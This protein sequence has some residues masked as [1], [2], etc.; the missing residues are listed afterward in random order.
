MVRTLHMSPSN[1]SGFH[2]RRLGYTACLLA[3]LWMVSTAAVGQEQIA[4]SEQPAAPARSVVA[5]PADA[6]SPSNSTNGSPAEARSGTSGGSREANGTPTEA[7]PRAT[8]ASPVAPMFTP[9]NGGGASV[10]RPAEGGVKWDAIYLRN[11]RGQLVPVPLDGDLKAFLEWRAAKNAPPRAARPDYAITSVALA[12]TAGDERAELTA[13]IRV[14][15]DRA[16]GWVRVPLRLNEAV[17]RDTSYD[18]PGTAAFDEF[19]RDAGYRWSL[20]GQGLHTLT[21]SVFVPVR[22]QSPTR[23]VQ[24][25]LPAT[26]VSQ[27]RI[28]VP[29]RR[30]SVKTGDPLAERDPRSTIRTRAVSDDATEIEIFGLE[31]R[32]DLT[33]QPLPDPAQVEM[34]LESLAS[35]AVKP[36]IDSVLLEVVQSVQARQ[37]SFD[38]L[39]VRL[40]SGFE[41]I[42][43]E[44]RRYA[45]HE[46]LPDERVAVKLTEPGTGPIELR[47]TLQAPLPES[48]RVL[49]EGFEVE[50]ARRQTGDIAVSHVEGLRIARYEA[51]NVHRI[52]AGD[53]IGQPS[54]ASAYRFLRQPFRLGLAVTRNPPGFTVQPEHKLHFSGQRAELTAEFK[55]RVYRGVVESLD[56]AWPN[57][58]AEGW[59]IEPPDMFAP[60]ADGAA[61]ERFDFD[62]D[63][64]SDV[65]RIQLRDRQAGEFT[66]RVRAGRKMLPEP[67]ATV[68]SLPGIDTTS[69]SPADLF[70][71]TADAVEAQLEPT[72]ETALERIQLAD[73]FPLFGEGSMAG[74]SPPASRNE[75]AHYR[76][77]SPSALLAVRLS[78]HE[79]IVRTSADA[80]VELVDGRLLVRQRI[81]YDVRYERL[82]QARLLVPRGVGE[83]VR[84][85][86]ADGA[87]L[88]PSWTDRGDADHRQATIRFSEPRIGWFEIV[89][90]YFVDP[91]TALP[92]VEPVDSKLPLVL[93]TEAPFG[94]LVLSAPP[95]ET[96]EVSVAESGWT[97]QM[98]M[99]DRRQWRT[100]TPGDAIVVRLERASPDIPQHYVVR[101]SLVRTVFD[102][103]GDASIRAQFR[104]RGDFTRLLLHVPEEQ[105]VQALWW[106]HETIAPERLVP[107]DDDGG[108]HRLEIADGTSGAVSGEHLL[109][110]DF[111]ESAPRG[112]TWA[113]ASRLAVARFPA[114]VRVDQS[115][116]EIV[117]PVDL[118][119][120]VTPRGLTPMYEWRRGTAFWTRNVRPGYADLDAW[121]GAGDGPA[122]E[123]MF[124]AGNSYL[125]ARFGPV[126][127][128]EFR[129]MSQSLIVLLGAGLALA[130]GFVL[131]KIPAT[132]DALT[133]LVIAFAGALVGL[134]HAEPVRV[135]LQPALLGLLLA[136]AAAAIEHTI[137]RRRAPSI[138]TLS[139]ASDFYAPSAGGSGNHR[140]LPAGADDPTAVRPAPSPFE[141]VST[142]TAGR[143]R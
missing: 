74:A 71:T 130:A 39:T 80:A 3:A 108:L 59:T 94:A 99:D 10:S 127:A 23:R 57:R 17:L 43:V 133:L 48:G 90:E 35:I 87:V 5:A 100:S 49:L 77:P 95:T 119:L 20:K 24:L 30:V 111:R 109:T 139:A 52:N 105:T 55:V 4:Q 29:M 123:P 114:N 33:W 120:F 126:D 89:A 91:G 31:Q 134:W 70:V 8:G 64:T 19:D 121:I 76:V 131:L 112:F 84:F 113:D 124:E 102:H 37:G 2:V 137:Q 36:T 15:V 41:L 128:L 135:L 38:S 85:L 125:F 13:T 115:L 92:P 82:P 78:L 9:S 88:T 83:Q 143:E 98:A 53:V 25:A 34:V 51:A 141:P 101:R 47:W 27:A 60:A 122:P 28:A 73:A 6:S 116:T 118:H 75:V 66:V 40:P 81:A 22:K 72:A 65:V 44:G 138:I 26:A 11:E 68:L 132:R 58:R 45:S 136:V 32:L 67:E 107:V 97:R 42:A 86:A 63:E 50:H 1:R 61:I 142:T 79:R 140:A 96:V 16:D 21:L 54:L 104:L 110:I 46:T 106:N 56:L 62:T 69:L 12:G 14:Q 129:A 18:G 7:T 93:P 117:L 103:N